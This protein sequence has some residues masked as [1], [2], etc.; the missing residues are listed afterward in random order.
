MSRKTP[1]RK[2]TMPGKK[3]KRDR[4]G[5]AAPAGRRPATAS[6]EEKER[7]ASLTN[8]ADLKRQQQSMIG[9]LSRRNDPVAKEV[10]DKMKQ[11][12]RKLQFEVGTEGSRLT[13]RI[14]CKQRICCPICDTNLARKR[15]INGA[16]KTIL[17]LSE[18]PSCQVCTFTL[19]MRSRRDIREV[20]GRCREAQ[21]R[22]REI[23]RDQRRKKTKKRIEAS[24]T[25]GGIEAVTFQ[26]N[27]EQF[28]AGKNP[29][30]RV[31]VRGVWLYDSLPDAEALAAEWKQFTGDSHH[32]HIKR[33]PTHAGDGDVNDLIDS[34]GADLRDALFWHLLPHLFTK[35]ARWKV[36]TAIKKGEHL[37]SA[38]GKLYRFKLEEEPDEE[39]PEVK[40][41]LEYRWGG[42]DYMPCVLP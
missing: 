25:I 22:M 16:L 6:I 19:T 33:L 35:S 13:E 5:A 41:L 42:H 32:V 20:I 12:S 39:S 18:N 28:L 3:A 31:L 8:Y 37:V 4:G 38:T 29:L 1:K 26:Q 23:G 40:K 36:R 10:A 9:Y 17:W 14:S 27:E 2:S 24:K 21:T 34:I 7:P 15:A 30:P 11:C